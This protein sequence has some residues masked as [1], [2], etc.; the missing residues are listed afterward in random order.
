MKSGHAA[1]GLIGIMACQANLFKVVDALG[2]VCR[3]PY[4]LHGGHKKGNQDRDNGDDD[5]K[6]D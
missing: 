6:F 3:R 5:K 2:L 1:G 4:F